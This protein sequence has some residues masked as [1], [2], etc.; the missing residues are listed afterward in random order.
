MEL[1][2]GKPPIICVDNEMGA[3]P[4]GVVVVVGCGAAAAAG[5]RGAVDVDDGI[6]NALFCCSDVPGVGTGA[7]D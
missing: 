3:I 2:L 4:D 7:A 1:G 6:G 5:V